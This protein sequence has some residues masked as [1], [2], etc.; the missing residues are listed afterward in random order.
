[1]KKAMAREDNRSV[2]TTP[3]NPAPVAAA[4]APKAAPV[5]AEPKPNLTR[6][7]IEVTLRA[8]FI[9]QGKDETEASKLARKRAL[10]MIPE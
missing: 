3:E 7:G 5:A 6:D 10:E 8:K 9:E 4:A 1:V 2:P